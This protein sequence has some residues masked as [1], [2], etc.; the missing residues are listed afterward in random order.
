M[1]IAVSYDGFGVV[2]NADAETNDSAQAGTGDWTETG[3]GTVNFNPDVYL[4][5]I[6]GSVGSIGNKYAN[7]SGNTTFL[8]P[9]TLNF[10]SGGNAENDL[11]YMPV[12]IQSIGQFDTLANWG[13][14]AQVG[15][16]VSTNRTSNNMYMYRIAGEDDGNG[17]NGGWKTFVLAPS[18]TGTS[19]GSPAANT[20]DTFGIWI[21]TNVSV[22]ADSIFQSQIIAAKGAIVTG[23]P[24]TTGEAFDELLGWCTDYDGSFS[25]PTPQAARAFGLLEFRGNTIFQKGGITIGNGSTLTT[26]SATGNSV[27]CEETAYYNGTAW[28]TTMPSDANFITTTA[29]ASLAFVNVNYSGFFKD[30]NNSGKIQWDTS[31]GNASSVSGGSLKNVGAWSVKSSDTFSGVVFQDNDAFNYGAASYTDCT[32]INVGQLT[33]S[34]ATFN[35][36]TFSNYEG[37]ANTSYLVYNQNADP[38]GELDGLTFTKGTAATHAIEFGTNVPS[39]MTLRN[40]TFND[41][42]ASDTQNDSTFHFKDTA[43]TITLNLVGC[44]GNFTYRSDGAT[45]VISAD[46]TSYSVKTVDSTGTA[47]PVTKV[48]LEAANATGDLPYQ[49]SVTISNASTTATVTH[50]SHGMA[51]GDKVVIRGASHNQNNGVHTITVTNTNTYTYTMASAPGSSPTGTITS[52]WVAIFGD[53]VAGSISAGRVFTSAQPVSG[54]ARKSSGAPYYKNAPLVGTIPTSGS[55]ELTAVM[56]ED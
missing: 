22:R 44:S 17:W 49:E 35:G 41:Y 53:T 47:I 32:F 55:Y 13:F 52:T 36:S 38:D 29:N 14:A 50:T 20:C 24:T 48:F 10:G 1:A 30:A 34:G 16:S 6:S 42:N 31:L 27:E 4:V 45:I 15:A 5:E 43:G 19:V 56:I 9:T 37:T 33:H 7:K 12:N 54:R 46:P 51:T 2:A 18:Q 8:S 26:F 3:G 39:S 25:G 23:S 11:I 40:C 28:V 21:D